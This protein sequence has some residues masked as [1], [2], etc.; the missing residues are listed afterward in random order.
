VFLFFDLLFLL[1][2]LVTLIVALSYVI[3]FVVGFIADYNLKRG[4]NTEKWGKVK[5]IVTREFKKLPKTRR[6]R[7]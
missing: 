1:V 5:E 2:I 6:R 3:L 4:R 7:W